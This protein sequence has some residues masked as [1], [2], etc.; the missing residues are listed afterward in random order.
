MPAAFPHTSFVCVPSVRV[1]C[2]LLAVSIPVTANEIALGKSVNVA[3]K[4][5]RENCITVTGLDWPGIDH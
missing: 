5:K 2:A 4:R 1:V 3:A